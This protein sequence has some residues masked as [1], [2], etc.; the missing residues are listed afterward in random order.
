MVIADMFPQSPRHSVAR[1]LDGLDLDPV[2]GRVVNV[3]APYNSHDRTA[4]R[5]NM[6]DSPDVAMLSSH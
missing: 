3:I 1:S 6:I 4:L 5:V 2:L